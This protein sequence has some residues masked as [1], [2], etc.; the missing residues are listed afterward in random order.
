[1]RRIS[2]VLAH[3][4]KSDIRDSNPSRNVNQQGFIGEI[5][6]I[7]QT[8]GL[9]NLIE[10]RKQIGLARSTKHVVC[11]YFEGIEE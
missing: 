11:K 3:E 5:E 8:K 10:Q 1:M 6:P 7:S 4:C 2:G 9:E